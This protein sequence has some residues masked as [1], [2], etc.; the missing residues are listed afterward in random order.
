MTLSSVFYFNISRKE[1][2][3][4]FQKN[5]IYAYSQFLTELSAFLK[6]RQIPIMLFLI[7]DQ[8]F[9]LLVDLHEIDF[10]QSLVYSDDGSRKLKY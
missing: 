5:M 2:K 7:T 10:N 6:T 3:Q 9:V 4:M 8:D 1:K